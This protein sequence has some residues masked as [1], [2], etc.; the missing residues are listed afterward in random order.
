MINAIILLLIDAVILMCL[1]R[2]LVKERAG[3]LSALIAALLGAVGAMLLTQFTPAGQYAALIGGLLA[4]V[5]VGL[6]IWLVFRVE[7]LSAILIGAIFLVVRMGVFFLIGKFLPASTTTTT[8]LN[9][10]SVLFL[11]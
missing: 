11:C 9:D 10:L 3:L 2:F 1:I 4:A 8:F 6:G 7:L 5:G